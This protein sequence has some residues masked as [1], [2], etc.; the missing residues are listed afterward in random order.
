MFRSVKVRSRIVTYDKVSF[1]K[2]RSKNVKFEK[3]G[4]KN[5]TFRGIL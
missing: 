5:D 1:E 2:V 4:L 3:G